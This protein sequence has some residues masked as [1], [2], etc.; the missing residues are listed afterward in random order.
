MKTK[1]KDLSVM[2]CL[3]KA[4]H[5]LDA[6]MKKQLLIEKPQE[7]GPAE[8]VGL[9]EAEVI[10]LPDEA[11]RGQ[12]IAVYGE[13]KRDPNYLGWF[14]FPT[15]RMVLYE[16]DGAG[17]SD[18]TGDVFDDHKCHKLLVPRMEAAFA[19]LWASLGEERFFAEGWNVYAGC[20]NYRRKREGRSYSI[21]S[22]GAAI[23]LTA[24]GSGLRTREC[25]FSIEGVEIMERHG[26]LWGPR[27]WGW[28]GE[29]EN[30]KY[31]GQYFDAMHFQAAIP[32]LNSNSYYARVG[33]P[34][35]IRRM[36][37]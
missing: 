12:V 27:A 5:F 33:L 28:P 16:R 19:E 4:D 37:V 9:A 15:S 32:Y 13:P 24:W 1:I 29:F 34:S 21:H 14:N 26:F 20:F 7:A 31:P 6:A 23:D 11:V 17:L 3:Y 36:G 2:D 25:G 35:N 22:W 30:S 8:K 18:H 10:F